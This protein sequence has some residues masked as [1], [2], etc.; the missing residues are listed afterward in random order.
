MRV[1]ARLA[2]HGGSS[3]SCSRS[4]AGS[5]AA[6]GS[7]GVLA[8]DA[9]DAHAAQQA[10][11]AA[12]LPRAARAR[13]TGS[14]AARA[15]AVVPQRAPP[16]MRLAR[17]QRRRARGPQQHVARRLALCAQRFGHRLCKGAARRSALSLGQR[18]IGCQRERGRL[19]HG[20]SIASVARRPAALLPPRRVPQA[21]LRCRRKGASTSTVVTELLNQRDSVGRWHT[22]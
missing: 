22:V 18:L 3:A 14:A 17:R 15:Q 5:T 13:A 20:G 6:S 19:A 16:A 10:Q 1:V 9:D 11:A 21:T 12:R 4:G 8:S 2:Q 7:A